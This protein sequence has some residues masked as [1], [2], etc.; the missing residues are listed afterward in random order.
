MEETKLVKLIDKAT[1]GVVSESS[2]RNESEP[3]GCL[4]KKWF[5]R[6]SALLWREGSM[7][8]RNLTDA[9]EHSGGVVGAAR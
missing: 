9:F 7:F 2:G 3:I 1:L 4:V 8:E 6:L 5:R